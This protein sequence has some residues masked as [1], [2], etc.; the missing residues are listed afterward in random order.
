MC[1]MKFYS[2]EVTTNEGEN[3]KLRTTYSRYKTIRFRYNKR[4]KTL[5]ATLISHNGQKKVIEK[6]NVESVEKYQD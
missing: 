6:V 1:K 4:N 5:K 3:G 2:L